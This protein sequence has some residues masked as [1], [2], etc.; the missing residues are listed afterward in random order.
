ML[1][2]WQ[3]VH[4]TALFK[5]G[6]GI[7]WNILS[8]KDQLSR[9]LNFIRYPV[10][11]QLFLTFALIAVAGYT[12]AI[13]QR[14]IYKDKISQTPI[15]LFVASKDSYKFIVFELWLIASV[16]I[17]LTHRVINILKLLCVHKLLYIQGHFK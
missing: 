4:E 1:H 7:V 9:N 6:S 16:V 2:Q 5:V 14:F 15:K 12:L 11:D 13:N 10:P 8:L 3:A 17:H